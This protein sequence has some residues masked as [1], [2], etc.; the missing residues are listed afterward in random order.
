MT[1]INFLFII[2]AV[3]LTIVIWF[4]IWDLIVEILF[5]VSFDVDV[6]FLAKARYLSVHEWWFKVLVFDVSHIMDNVL[7]GTFKLFE[8]VFNLIFISFQ[9]RFIHRNI[10]LITFL[11]DTTEFHLLLID[12]LITR[13][14]LTQLV[15][16]ST[17]TLASCFHIALINL[18]WKL[19]TARILNVLYIWLLNINTIW[20]CYITRGYII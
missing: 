17:G 12:L 16:E 15:L 5:S 8:I 2:V 6:V 10:I 1:F 7:R 4:F 20:G 9:T 3:R 19:Y 11:F 18:M 13:G 14:V